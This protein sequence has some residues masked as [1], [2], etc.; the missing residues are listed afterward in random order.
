MAM[1]D[2]PFS[3][4]TP[5]DGSHAQRVRRG[6]AAPDL[7][8]VSLDLDDICEIA[9]ANS[10][11]RSKARTLPSRSWDAAR[12]S[13][14]AT[15]CQPRAGAPNGLASVASSRREYSLFFGSGSPF[16]IASSA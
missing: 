4:L 8:V 3:V 1:H 9:G 13:V 12:S 2:P 5:K 16:T 10:E 11:M 15:F 6:F 14:S 7:A